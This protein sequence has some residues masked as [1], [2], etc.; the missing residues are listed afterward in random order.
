MFFL[1]FSF[2]GYFIF[3][4]MKKSLK[5][6][7]SKIKQETI[8]SVIVSFNVDS[9]N[10]QNYKFKAGQYLTLS[11]KIN[12]QTIK[13]SYSIC[14]SP[15]SKKLQVGVKAIK[16]GIFSNYVNDALREGDILE[17]SFPEGRFV[18]D[19]KNRDKNYCAFAA[20]SG[21]TPI[22]SIAEDILDS[23]EKSIFILGYGNKTI[24]STMF[25]ESIGFLLKKFPKRFFCYNIYSSE[26]VPLSQFG[27]IDSGFINYVLNQHTEIK[28][29]KFLL[30]GPEMM[31]K[32]CS[33][34]LEKLSYNKENILFELF[35]S[36]ENEKRTISN[37]GCRATLI[38]DKE[39][40]SLDIPKKMTILDAALQKNIDVPYS[41][42][43]GVCS[44]CLAKISSGTAKMIQNNILTESEIKDG[45]VLTCQAVPQSSSIIINFDDV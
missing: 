35:Y 40:F 34:C 26:K 36:T 6:F 28:F 30:C 22:I 33:E 24:A 45:L 1:L 23:S 11:S 3:E 4:Q 25:K 17:V 31:I 42:Q 29:E 10:A 14:S 15:K 38:Y 12:G 21:I 16:N 19:K 7:V 8:D 44:S 5:L 20:G 13:R 2:D 18:L 27:R 32:N 37:S 39:N 9:Q 43:G 41:C